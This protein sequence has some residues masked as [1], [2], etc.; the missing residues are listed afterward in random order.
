HAAG[1]IAKAVK[2]LTQREA[3]IIGA[4]KRKGFN[5]QVLQEALKEAADIH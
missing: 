5:W 4:S 2:L 1:E 3:V